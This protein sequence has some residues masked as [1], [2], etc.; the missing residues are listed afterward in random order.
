MSNHKRAKDL[1]PGDRILVQGK[2][3][4]YYPTSILSLETVNATY[5]TVLLVSVGLVTFKPDQWV[6]MVDESLDTLSALA[7]Q[8]RQ[9]PEKAQHQKYKGIPIE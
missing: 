9:L 6:Q 2:D 4:F 7:P 1:M 8:S 5:I 3:G